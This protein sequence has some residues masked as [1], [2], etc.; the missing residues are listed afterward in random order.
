[1]TA[2][3]L[4]F[5]ALTQLNLISTALHQLQELLSGGGLPQDPTHWT[6]PSES[7][8]VCQKHTSTGSCAAWLM[9]ALPNSLLLPS[10]LSHLFF[11]P[12]L[13]SSPLPP[14]PSPSLHL[15]QS[16]PKFQDHLPLSDPTNSKVLIAVI[17][18]QLKPHLEVLYGNGNVSRL[19]VVRALFYIALVQTHS[20]P[21]QI[22]GASFGYVTFFV[23]LCHIDF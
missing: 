11:P 7:S 13:L 19:A 22:S 4:H 3:I 5:R 23:L 21:S 2:K 14:I 20:G 16:L 15:S 18:R 9:S 17:D 10:L 1:M 12:P 8:M 6:R